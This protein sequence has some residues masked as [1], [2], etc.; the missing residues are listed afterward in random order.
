MRRSVDKETLYKVTE[1]LILRHPFEFLGHVVHCMVRCEFD[2]SVA[3]GIRFYELLH[4]RERYATD[5]TPYSYGWYYDRALNC[6]GFHLY[7]IAVHTGVREM[8][9][10]AVELLREA[11]RPESVEDVLQLAPHNLKVAEDWLLG[12]GA[13]QPGLAA[14][15]ALKG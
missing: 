7:R 13:G 1:E 10:R 3:N 8:A 5:R 6:C 15:P 12:F 4:N 9:E 11:S 14:S 2:P